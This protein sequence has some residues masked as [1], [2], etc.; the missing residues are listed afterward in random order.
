MKL[1]WCQSFINDVTWQRRL[2]FTG[3]DAVRRLRVPVALSYLCLGCFR[4]RL[5]KKTAVRELLY[6]C[7]FISFEYSHWADRSS[8]IL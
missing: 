3:D 8:F 4:P 7:H 2:T 6:R 1:T 5:K